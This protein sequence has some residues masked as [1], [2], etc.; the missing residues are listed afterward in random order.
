M[1]RR[2]PNVPPLVVLGNPENRRVRLFQEALAQA[3]HAPARVVSWLDFV[4][5]PSALSGVAERE[6][7]L[8]VDSFGESFEVERALL[9]LGEP[10]A[11]SAGV[12]HLSVPAIDALAYERGRILAP[13]Q[14]HFGFERALDAL[15]GLLAERRAWRV[16]QP[17][18]DVRALFDKRATA[19]RFAAMGIAIAEPLEFPPPPDPFSEGPDAL[20]AAMRAAQAHDVFVKLSCGSSASCLALFSSGPA[21]EWLFSSMEI[22]RGGGT[23]RLYN[24][25]R[26][27][28]YTERGAIDLLLGT[29]LREGSH[30][31]RAAPK[32]RIG[33]AFF[34]CRVLVVAGRA[35][36]RVVRKSRHPVT[37]LHL[38][39][40]RGTD[41][42]VARVVGADAQVRA[43]AACERAASAFGCFH[44]G[45]DVMFEP[46]GAHRVLEANA[47]GD[48][49]PNL[50][51]DGL[52][53]Y[54]WQVREL[55]RSYASRE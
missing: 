47:F 48:L 19:R 23:P 9:R 33:G 44:V 49:L 11:R 18:E 55:E 52:S 8:R 6:I 21:G 1:R 41:D 3:G 4:R 46:D 16:L 14:L 32:A 42:E 12:E 5:D 37:N 17:P 53:V 22:A 15:A 35:A 40:V 43:E 50:E 13:R 31:E 2:P 25:L 24:S 27:R 29:L 54:A 30:V 45:V 39:G 36:F 7:V 10:D 20:R 51:R 26:P 38:G 28:R 34:D